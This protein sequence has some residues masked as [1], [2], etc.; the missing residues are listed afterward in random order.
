[1]I[2]IPDHIGELAYVVKHRLSSHQGVRILQ[3]PND[4]ERYRPSTWLLL[5]DCDK[6]PYEYPRRIAAE[7]I[8][9]LVLDPDATAAWLRIGRGEFVDRICQTVDRFIANVRQER[10]EKAQRALLFPEWSP[11]P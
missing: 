1:M 5:I 4:S 6:D 2:P 8:S 11:Y 3:G 9:K 7:D 10:A